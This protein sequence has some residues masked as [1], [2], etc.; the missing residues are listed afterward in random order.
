MT[1]AGSHADVV[2]VGGGGMG[3]AAA[4]EIA[5]R[6]RS[7]IVLDRFPPPHDR[8]SSHGQSRLI[9]LAYFEH[10]DY[11]PLLRRA[12]ER[13]RALEEETGRALLTESGLLLVG[14]PTGEAIRGT[15]HAAAVHGLPLERLD[16]AAARAA[17]PLFS[18]PDDWV[19]LLERR[20]GWLRVEECVAA[21]VARAVRHG[22][23]FDVG[24]TVHGWRGGG[25]E[26]VIDTDR[27]TYA[28]DRVVL[29]PGPWAGDLL[30]LPKVTFRVLRKGL[31]WFR[32]RAWR[33]AEFAPGTL[34][35]FAF[36]LP[37]GFFYGF[38]EI[39]GSG[40]KVAEHTGGTPIADPLAVDR[41]IDEQE[42]A[43][44]RRFLA[45]HVPAA[46]GPPVRSAACLYTMS[47]DGHFLLG[48]HPADPRVAIAAGF[49]GHGFKFAAVVGEVLADL[50][51]A[52]ATALPIGFLSPT[53]F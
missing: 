18:L 37:E 28:A 4:A 47:P 6:G 1:P 8:G 35:C 19:A 33:R 25:R 40:V 22:A 17:S 13:W 29:A 15:L 39:D 34:P 9:R 21:H 42:L 51:L 3:S 46:D 41:G 53:R 30:Q 20:G 27:G 2:V 36:D 49:S 10:P 52:G 23:R 31:F 45:A 26:I 32:P 48:L 16:T 38:P 7:V 14:P 12:Y 44:V 24:V 50:G 11:V 43:R 5:A